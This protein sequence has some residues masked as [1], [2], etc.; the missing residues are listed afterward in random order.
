MNP[1]SGMQGLPPMFG[2]FMPGANFSMMTPQGMGQQQQWLN[3]AL[4]QQQA[5]F[6]NQ[7]AAAAQAAAAPNASMQGAAQG[8]VG[9]EAAERSGAPASSG[10]SEQKSQAPAS[11]EV[12]V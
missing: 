10:S 7:A 4:F 9:A 8:Q 3:P 5:M 6:M 2:G 1:G 12:A 11:T